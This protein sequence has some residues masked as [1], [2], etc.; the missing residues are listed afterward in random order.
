[1]SR[2]WI[3]YEQNLELDRQLYTA[4]EQCRGQN[5][6]N[7]QRRG[8]NQHG[9]D[10]QANTPETA[11]LMKDVQADSSQ[12]EKITKNA[13]E[14]PHLLFTNTVGFALHYDSQESNHNGYWAT[15]FA[16]LK[17]GYDISSGNKAL[18]L[19]AAWAHKDHK[20]A[21]RLL[22]YKEQFGLVEVVKALNLLDSGRK[23]R[24][25]EKKMKRMELQKGKPKKSKL[26]KCKQ[27][28]EN[29]KAVQPKVGSVSG[30]LIRHVKNWVQQQTAKELEYFALF[31]PKESW[32]KL[33]D[34]CHLNPQK[35]FS[36]IPWFLPFCFGEEAP[37]TS[38]V[39]KCSLI[40]KDNVN[41]LI[42][43]T[44][45]PYSHI[46]SLAGELNKESKTRIATYTES[47][48]TVLWNYED[49]SCPEVD[50]VINERLEGGEEVDLTYGKLMERLL[51]LAM[52]AK[53]TEQ[54]P[55]MAALMDQAEKGLKNI[56]VSLKAP[57]AVLGDRSPSM[58]VAIRTS[59]IIASLVANI[60][61][62][63]LSFFASENYDIEEVPKTVKEVNWVD[64]AKH[65]VK[66]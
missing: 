56:S 45:V 25:W 49:L 3:V 28:I 38:L 7:Y 8:R 40:N 18:I 16:L 43:G 2:S 51:M 33:A 64:D 10:N 4:Q 5:R 50:S 57:V 58:N 44:D 15:L 65:A 19:A 30:A 47:L 35:D 29:L 41:E 53:G 12:L 60:T 27:N 23:I 37:D 36:S 9:R 42:L 46:K 26:S 1:M 14:K 62:A 32:K 52:K 20:M 66:F 54:V 24:E 61:Q 34:I 63:K 48:S 55:F 21:E 39:K 31:Y 59:T 11:S 22:S 13:K 17:S 6:R